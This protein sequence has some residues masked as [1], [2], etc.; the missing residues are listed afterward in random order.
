M[1]RRRNRTCKG[2]GKNIRRPLRCINCGRQWKPGKTNR[3]KYTTL[4]EGSTSVRASSAGAFESKR[5]KH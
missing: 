5:R 2:C 4:D 3:A 1:S